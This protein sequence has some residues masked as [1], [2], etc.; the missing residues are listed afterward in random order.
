MA[1]AHV[2][3]GAIAGDGGHGGVA[4]AP[5]RGGGGAAHLHLEGLSGLQGEVRPVEGQGAGGAGAAPAGGGCAGGDGVVNQT[6]LG[7]A[8]GH[9]GGD[10]G[11]ALLAAVA[12]LAVLVHRYHLRVAAAPGDLPGGAVGDKGD[13]QGDGIGPLVA[14]GKLTL[15]QSEAGGRLPLGDGVAGG[16]RHWRRA[17]TGGLGLRRAGVRGGGHAFHRRGV[18]RRAVHVALGY[19]GPDDGDDDDDRRHDQGQGDHRADD[20]QR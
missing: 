6:G 11:A 5:G 8:A 1:L 15:A 14:E 12:H 20:L 18:V 19:Q 3:D 2:L 7:D 13:R 4:D 9:G 10:G 17:L 16:L